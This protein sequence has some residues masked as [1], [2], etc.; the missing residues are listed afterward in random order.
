LEDIKIKQKSFEK[1]I[2]KEIDSKILNNNVNFDAKILE[3]N[4]KN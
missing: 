2:S 3:I 1:N 4:N